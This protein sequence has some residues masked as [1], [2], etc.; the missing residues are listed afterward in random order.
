MYVDFFIREVHPMEEVSIY[1]FKNQ[2]IQILTCS[3]PW[4]IGNEK[5]YSIIKLHDA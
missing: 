5:L 1:D 2:T 4:Q 3:I